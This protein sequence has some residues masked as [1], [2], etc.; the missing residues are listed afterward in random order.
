MRTVLCY[1]QVGE[2]DT[3]DAETCPDCLFDSVL[4]FP[5]TSLSENGVSPFGHYVACVR[6]ADMAGGS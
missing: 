3:D 4:K 1:I 5:L 2:P 6:C